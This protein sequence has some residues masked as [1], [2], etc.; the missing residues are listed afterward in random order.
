MKARV[1]LLGVVAAAV[2]LAGA[3]S[4]ARADEA[5]AK[6]AGP[7][8]VIVGAGKFL[9]KAID[10]RP[11]A[12]A[13]A[14]ALYD[15]LTDPKYL[16]AKPERTRL[17][18]SA[19]DEKRNGEVATH[20]AVVKAVEA[21]T[22]QTAK[23]DLIVL[24]FFGRGATA[25]DKTAFLTADTV[26]KDRA[27][28]ALVFGNDLEPAF[29]K[30]KGQKILLLMDVNYKGFK[31]GDEK[32]AEPTLTDV[33]A[34][35]FGPEDKED[36]VRP[37]DRLM[38]LSGFISSDPLAKGDMGLFAST[39]I[40]ALKG[41]ADTPP[42]NEGYEPDGLVTTDE[43]VKYLEKEI[44][45]QARQ[46]GKTDKEK[47]IQAVPIGAR[48]SHFVVTKN[49][50]E[51]AKVQK[52]LD[53]LAALAKAG[54]VNEELA[55][56]GA[57]LLSRMP[58]LKSGQELRKGYQKLADGAI[59]VEE[60]TAARTEIKEG[61]KLAA[62]DAESYAR[63]V[64]DAAELVTRVY[65]K[66]VTAGDLTAAAIK[67]M[68]RRIEESLP[69]DLENA[70]KNPKDLSEE[71]RTALLADARTR[72]GKR[73]DLDE[74]KD[75]DVSILM[76]MASLSDPYTVY[77]DKETVRKMASA[78][79]GRFPGV[80]IQIRR[81]A[82]RDGLLVVTPIKG[83]PAFK[84]GI[85]AGDLIT[86]VIRSVDNET[87]KPLPTEAQKE[88]STKGMKTDDAIAI[89]TGKPATPITL[90]VDRD[91]KE[92]TFPLE[93]NWVN[94]ETVLGVK[95]NESASWEF[96]ID[97]KYK[98]GYIRLT[99]FTQKTA[100]DLKAA[101]EGL[102][103]KGGLNGLVLDLRGNP[104]GYLTAATNVCEQF[105]GKTKLVTVKPRP[106]SG[107][108]RPRTYTGERAGDKTFEVV[109][110]VNGHSASASEIVAA[111][112]QDHERA[113]IIGERSYGKGSVQ[114]V[115]PFEETGGEIKLTIARY[116]PPSDRNID[117]LATKGEPDEE[118]GVKPDKGFEVKL[119]REETNELETLMRDLEI[120]TPNGG[121]KKEVS[122]EKDK[123]LKAALAHLRSVLDEKRK[124]ATK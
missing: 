30:V 6:P 68:Y 110:L 12:D 59:K 18:L 3:T 88:F 19:P 117:K 114:D 124:N 111:C 55:K 69:T 77:F 95:R 50:T 13:D 23:D 97:P 60:L 39:V 54:T 8:V 64:T 27:K 49:P 16:G 123:Q 103:A 80:G 100:E 15:L 38:I 119:T 109:V 52:Q 82:V 122:E 118:W 33:D 89:I 90:M 107:A 108:G 104:G 7:F 75:A 116:Y 42:N 51:T 81:D 32:V 43:L 28:T 71:K 65:I 40:D 53:A 78:L 41:A 9:D 63:K 93:R 91:G 79:R 98:I 48:T 47:E 21:A 56:E 85:Q 17:L 102:K 44:P 83:S 87:G 101:I 57:V 34:L 36:S 92:L 66:P 94:V 20:D 67:G 115:A 61:L 62:K 22:S 121:K 10:P 106:G 99:Q 5:K 46:I 2:S 84:A 72:L 105:V 96:T 26:F 35:L 11:T 86:K 1:W 37:Q 113:T 74:N 24:A 29:K 14:K 58:K 45:N 73:E 120:I 31:A 70:L 112:L 76:M 25:G 4:P